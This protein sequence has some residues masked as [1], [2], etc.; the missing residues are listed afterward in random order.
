MSAAAM[1]A[2]YLCSTL[3]LP[4]KLVPGC[5]VTAA[6]RQLVQPLAQLAPRSKGS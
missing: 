3:C 5:Q 1:S 4:N 2:S 6:A